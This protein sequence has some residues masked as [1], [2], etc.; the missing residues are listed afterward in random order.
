MLS[1]K[2]DVRLNYGTQVGW[3]GIKQVMYNWKRYLELN[4]NDNEDSGRRAS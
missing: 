1:H 3:T 2:K 4:I